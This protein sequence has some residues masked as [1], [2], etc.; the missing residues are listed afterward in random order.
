MPLFSLQ[1]LD[2]QKTISKLIRICIGDS[3]GYA[4]ELVMKAKSS[5]TNEN[6]CRSSWDLFIELAIVVEVSGSG[7]G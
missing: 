5:V 2:R 4:L 1:P 6:S 3:L 7:G